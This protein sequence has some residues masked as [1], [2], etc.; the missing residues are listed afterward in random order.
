MFG[1][2][3]HAF[4]PDRG[5]IGP[6]PR[7]LVTASGF[8]DTGGMQIAVIGA[9]IA[10]LAATKVLTAVGHEVATFDTEP[11]VGGVWSPTRHYPGLTTQNTRMT[12]EYSDHPAPASWPDYP[13][14]GQWHSYLR[15]YVNRFG[16]DASLRPGTRVS[17]ASPT[18]DGWDLQLE[19]GE[20]VQAGHLVV[21]N[22]VFSRPLIP[23]WPG[24]EAHQ[25]AGGVVKAPSQQ[26]TLDD[27]RGK[28]VVVVGY[29]KSACDTATAL[30]A[31]AA[32]V[33]VVPRRLLW[34]GPKVLLGRHFEDVAITRLGEVLFANP[35]RFGP[36]FGV[37]SRATVKKQGLDALGLIPP[38][39]FDDIAASSASL[40]TEGFFDAVRGGTIA[41][42]RDRSVAEVRGGADGPEAVLDD[43]AVLP[44]DLIVAAT[45]FE[46]SLPFLDAAQ[47]A[48]PTLRN[49]AGEFEL[50]R[51][52][53]PHEAPN[54][55]FAGYN[56]SL[57]SS[58]SAEVGAIWIAAHLAGALRLPSPA[59]RRAQVQA[60]LAARSARMRGKTASGT[61][62]L[63]R[64]LGN[65]DR[66]LGDLHAVLPRRTRMAQWGRRSYSADFRQTLASAVQ[67]LKKA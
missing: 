6:V 4:V 20:R 17:L 66:L 49:A 64:S 55:T 63:P 19:S 33:T 16:F 50:F 44:A 21:A 53:L 56:T 2:F 28:H 47:D 67:T 52:V 58:L 54:L 62:V 34:K 31:V 41:V 30:S 1:D 24:L 51:N 13:S 7:D 15:G 12:Y 59:E 25:S 43:G 37:L 8:C 23:D 27:A 46:Q 14:A 3:R 65:I 10:G 29:G 39:R 35:Q 42:R 32:S 48:A 40:A 18:A 38:G 45:G 5:A 22:G 11:E 57:V 61:V 36:V 9:G 26:L 60:D